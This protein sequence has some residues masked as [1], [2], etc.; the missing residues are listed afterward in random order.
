MNT[1]TIHVAVYDGWADWEAGFALAHL[2]SGDWRADGKRYDVVTV[3]ET[4]RPIRTKGGLTLH[5]DTTLDDLDPAHSAMLIL[6]GG[7]S[8]MVGANHG[9]AVMAGRFLQVGVPVAAICG[10]TVGLAAAGLLNDRDH[11]SNAPQI[12][13]VGAYSG[14]DRYQ[15]QLA[16]TD[17][18][19]ITASGVAPVEFARA[20]FDQLAFYSEEVSDSWYL[21]YGKQDPA[22]YFALMQA[23]ANVG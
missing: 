15:Q 13:Q 21:M 5:P 12:L 6:P 19:L 22:G 2:A 4:S 20:I 17:S 14:Q 10:A 16:V 8:W 1:N 11:T 9:F 18:N 7:D 3:G 23:L